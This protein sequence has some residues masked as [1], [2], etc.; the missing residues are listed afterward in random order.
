GKAPKGYDVYRD[1]SY[2]EHVEREDSDSQGT[3]S[4]ISEAT[5]SVISEATSQKYL[6]DLKS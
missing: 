4:V 3:I 6:R 5:N 1:P 2:F